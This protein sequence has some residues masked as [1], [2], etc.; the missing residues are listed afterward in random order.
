MR[1][2]SAGFTLLEIL[3]VLI[4]VGLLQIT[5]WGGL[6]IGMRGWSQVETRATASEAANTAERI[7]RDILGNAEPEDPGCTGDS[8]RL[9]CATLLHIPGG[10]HIL[11]V[12]AAIGINHDTLLLRWQERSSG[13]PLGKPLPIHETIILPRIKSITF[14]YFQPGE[15]W[16]SRWPD[17]NAPDLIRIRITPA[18]GAPWPTLLIHPIRVTPL[19]E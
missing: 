16:K 2:S 1:R 7:L 5:L 6:R 14:S 15:G 9:I 17:G 19:Q 11:P 4:I 3:V 12:Q 10:D 8:Q 18:S 13:I